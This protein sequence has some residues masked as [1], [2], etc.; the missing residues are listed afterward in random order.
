MYF[1]SAVEHYSPSV[2][3]T[4]IKTVERSR[5]YRVYIFRKMKVT[6][7]GHSSVFGNRGNVDR[8]EPIPYVSGRYVIQGLAGFNFKSDRSIDNY[9]GS[10]FKLWFHNEIPLEQDS[11]V[12]VDRGKLDVDNTLD[13]GSN[14]FNIGGESNLDFKNILLKNDIQTFLITE[15]QNKQGWGTEIVQF[16]TLVPKPTPMKHAF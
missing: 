12:Y 6:T 15:I 16:A 2:M 1:Q 7:D 13:R 11:V 10:K 9:N 5:G 8:Y 14:V 3:R 4:V